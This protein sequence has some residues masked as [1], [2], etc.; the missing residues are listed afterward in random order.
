MILPASRPGAASEVERDVPPG[1]HKWAFVG[2]N[3]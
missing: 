2:V 1:D 3:I